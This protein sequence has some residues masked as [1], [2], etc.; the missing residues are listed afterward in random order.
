MK[1]KVGGL[2]R[3]HVREDAQGAAVREGWRAGGGKGK[4]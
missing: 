4:R 3:A 1:G 2:E